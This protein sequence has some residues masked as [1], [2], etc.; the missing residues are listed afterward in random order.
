LPVVIMEALA[1]RRPVIGT[2]VGG[3][4][5][6]VEPGKCG[7]IV[8][9]GSEH[10]LADAMREALALSPADLDIMGRR[11]AQRVAAAHDARIEARVLARLFLDVRETWRRRPADG[12]A[13][14]AT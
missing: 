12:L 6:L 10:D 4:A 13:P 3:I 2:A 14:R 9:P 5:E 7:W 1:L 11:G 8:P